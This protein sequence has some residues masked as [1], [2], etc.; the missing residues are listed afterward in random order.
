MKPRF[1]SGREA[2]VFRAHTPDQLCGYHPDLIGEALERGEVLRY[3]LYSPLRETES[4]VCGVRAAPGSHAL[5]V[6]DRR[7]VLSRDPHRY[8]GQRSVCAI[9]FEAVL[10]IEL[11]E[12]LTLGWLVLRFAGEGVL[13]T[14]SAA[15]HASGIAHFR[16]AL[17]AFRMAS[18]G[19]AHSFAEPSPL[20]V[21]PRM[22]AYLRSE[23][24]PLLLPGERP[25]LA[26]ESQETWVTAGTRR[27]RRCVSPSLAFMVT[28]RAVLWAENE[29]PLRPKTLAFGVSVACVDRRRVTEARLIAEPGG[30]TETLIL[31]TEVAGVRHPFS[32]V[33]DGTSHET[34]LRTVRLFGSVDTSR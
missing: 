2:W 7:L 34:A 24:E 23:L 11:G 13:M 18:P 16:A 12:A 25:C 14:E 27:T 15:F 3:L 10:S 20:P 28:D 19:M 9:P 6:T 29:R 32:S 4:A 5:A 26:I 8:D 21:L 1:T 22:P 17:R 31:D 30:V 33:L